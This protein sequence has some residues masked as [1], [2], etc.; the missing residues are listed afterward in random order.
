LPTLPASLKQR[1]RISW[2]AAFDTPLS[3][4]HELDEA[5]RTVA[6]AIVQDQLHPAG[7]A[8]VQTAVAKL[9]ATLAQRNRDET[10]TKAWALVMI[11]ELG[12]LPADLVNGACH[13][14]LLTEKWLPTLAE[15]IRLMEPELTK[16]RMMLAALLNPADALP[17]QVAVQRADPEHVARLVARLREK[18]A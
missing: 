7:P 9:K 17:A 15:L 4:T 16:R 10:D 1:V 14:W 11:S 18:L 8:Q 13:E 5:Q 2:N 3:V 6:L 12:K